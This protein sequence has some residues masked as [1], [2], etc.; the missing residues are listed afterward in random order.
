MFGRAAICNLRHQAPLAWLRRVHLFK[1]PRRSSRSRSAIEPRSIPAREFLQLPSC[2]ECRSLLPIR[3]AAECQLLPESFKTT[4]EVSTDEL[5]AV[6]L[7]ELASLVDPIVDSTNIDLALARSSTVI[8]D[9]VHCG[10]D[11]ARHSHKTLRSGQS[12][13]LSDFF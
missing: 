1:P 8:R 6:V 4:C 9:R 3:P 12:E 13:Q 10:S 7:V 5:D 2:A 11:G